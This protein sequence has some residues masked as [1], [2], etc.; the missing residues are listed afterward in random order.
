MASVTSVHLLSAMSLIQTTNLNNTWPGTLNGAI[1]QPLVRAVCHRQSLNLSSA[2]RDDYIQFSDE[3]SD[4]NQLITVGKVISQLDD[5]TGDFR[6]AEEAPKGSNRHSA[7]LVAGGF[8]ISEP[9]GYNVVQACAVD[10]VWTRTP[11][12][13]TKSSGLFADDMSSLFENDTALANVGERVTMTPDFVEQ[14]FDTAFPLS[15]LDWAG[16]RIAIST[17]LQS[18]LPLLLAYAMTFTKSPIFPHTLQDAQ[19]NSD[20]GNIYFGIVDYLRISGQGHW[21]SHLTDVIL[22]QDLIMYGN[23]S[24]TMQFNSS[25]YSQLEISGVS[26]PYGYSPAQVTVQLSLVVFLIYVLIVLFH[27]SYALIYGE[28]SNGWHSIGELFML[29]LNSH[30]PDRVFDNTSVGVST[31]EP[32]REPISIQVNDKNSLEVLFAHD[33]ED[34]ELRFRSVK[35]NERYE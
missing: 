28:A 7:V 22:V 20:L 30:K 31:M 33:H 29:A 14:V 26:T 6:F 23:E 35:A 18:S 11:C 10:A 5:S 15:K 8:N 32:F 13:Y 12:G 24:V 21:L 25:T 9:S 1:E 3:Y 19:T 16:L 2:A 34:E 27:L 17:R 4:L